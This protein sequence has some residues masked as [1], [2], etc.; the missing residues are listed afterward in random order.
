LAMIAAT[1][2]LVRLHDAE[3]VATDNI[4]VPGSERTMVNQIVVEA[5]TPDDSRTTYRLRV[6]ANLIAEGLT[7]VQAQFLFG[8]IVDRIDPPRPAESLKRP[9]TLRP[10]D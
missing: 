9:G 2:I 5:E 6:D 8:E 4:S 1:F 3:M 7:A 10:R